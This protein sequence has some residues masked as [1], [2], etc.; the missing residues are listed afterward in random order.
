MKKLF[1]FFAFVVGALFT[2]TAQA[3]QNNVASKGVLT[4]LPITGAAN[5]ATASLSG[6]GD[7]V[8][9][10]TGNIA[11]NGDL[12]IH[13][14]FLAAAQTYTITGTC[15]LY[16]S[17]DGIT[18]VKACPTVT[19]TTQATLFTVKGDGS[20]TNFVI[21][22]DYFLPAQSQTVA[23]ESALA[24]INGAISSSPI[25]RFNYYMVKIIQTTA[26][27]S[28]ATASASWKLQRLNTLN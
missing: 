20:G 23:T 24:S 21:G 14:Q 1:I 5:T 15:D 12:S 27:T 9:L 11:G 16:G 17:T 19:L 13:V 7:S 8:F 25:S 6:S 28:S 26:A 2:E 3:Q 10:K 4:V 18:Y 22:V